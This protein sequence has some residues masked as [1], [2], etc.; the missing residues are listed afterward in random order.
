MG[1]RRGVPGGGPGGAPGGPPEFP[2]NFS[3]GFPG[4]RG[5]PRPGV[6]I[7]GSGSPA[8]GHI[9]TDPTGDALHF[10]LAQC[11]GHSPQTLH[12]RSRRGASR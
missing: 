3:Q 8:L 10:V 7:R 1:P 6:Q 4:P 12:H 2:G 5:A 9:I 11:I